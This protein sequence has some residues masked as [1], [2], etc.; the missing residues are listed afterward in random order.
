MRWITIGW[1]STGKTDGRENGKDMS[2][3]HCDGSEF[4]FFLRC[5]KVQCVGMIENFRRK[6]G[7]FDGLYIPFTLEFGP[8]LDN[9]FDLLIGIYALFAYL[10]RNVDPV[11]R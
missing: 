11:I 6:N 4:F 9:S 2:E 7:T 1:C 3:V 8:N 10:R 5:D